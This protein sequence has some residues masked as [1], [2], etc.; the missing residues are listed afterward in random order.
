MKRQVA[1]VGI[2]VLIVLAG[3]VGLYYLTS[4]D[5]PTASNSVVTTSGGYQVGYNPEGVWA[6]YLG[7]LPQGYKAAAHLPNAPTWPCPAGM[8]ASACAQFQQTCGNGIC[9]PNESCQ[10]CPIDCAPSG[11]ATCDPY[12]GRIGAPVNVCFLGGHA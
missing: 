5:S 6:N 10:T 4:G 1:F 2:I 12:T 9:D 11:D 8:S 3:A 7:Y